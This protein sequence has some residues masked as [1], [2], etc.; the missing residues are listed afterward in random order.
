MEHLNDLNEDKV[1]IFDQFYSN[2]QLALLKVFSF[3]MDDKQRPLIAVLIKFMEFDIC[4][5]KSMQQ[6][7]MPYSCSHSK[8]PQRMEDILAEIGDYLPK[9]GRE[10][11]EQMKSMKETYETY[12]QMMEMMNMMQQNSDGPMDLESILNAFNT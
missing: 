2:D 3:F 1:R 11:M 9:E 7:E 12:S 10:M 4:L 5:H 8:H 6:H